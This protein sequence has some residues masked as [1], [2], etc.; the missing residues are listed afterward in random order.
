MVFFVIELRTRAVYIAGVRVN[1][2]GAWMMQ[3]VCNIFDHED[4][5]LRNATRLIHDRD[6]LFTQAWVEL[7]KSSEVKSVRIPASSPNSN[8]YAE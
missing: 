3:I 4:G 8:L 7:L 1:P 2:D 6:P 5:F